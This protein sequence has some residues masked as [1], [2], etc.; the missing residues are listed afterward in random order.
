LDYYTQMIGVQV[1][2]KVFNQLLNTAHPKIANHFR[3]VNFESMFF[4]LNWFICLF[5]EKLDEKVTNI[6]NSHF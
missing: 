1:D 5:C 6:S 4:S 3:K 2:V